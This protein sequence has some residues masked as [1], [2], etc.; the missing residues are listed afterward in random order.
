[1]IIWNSRWNYFHSPELE[2]MLPNAYIIIKL[3]Q[4]GL[5]DEIKQISL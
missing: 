2:K 3:P 5:I 4:V 1:M